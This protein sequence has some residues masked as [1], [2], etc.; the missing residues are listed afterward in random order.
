MKSKRDQA[1]KRIKFYRGLGLVIGPLLGYLGSYYSLSVSGYNID[2]GTIPGYL[3]I[4]CVVIMILAV[5]LFYPK[6]NIEKIDNKDKQGDY[7]ETF[8]HDTITSYD[9]SEK[10]RNQVG[11]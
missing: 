2:V 1:K 11:N 7:S 5:S 10:I 8:R 9:S 6:I 4:V 3:Q